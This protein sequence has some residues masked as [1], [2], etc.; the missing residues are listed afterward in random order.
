MGLKFKE[1]KIPYEI[2]TENFCTKIEN[3]LKKNETK[4]P[5]KKKQKIPSKNLKSFTKRNGKYFIKK[6]KRENRYK[7]QRENLKNNRYPLYFY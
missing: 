2:T 1:T 4:N 3:P 5:F 6:K 7:K